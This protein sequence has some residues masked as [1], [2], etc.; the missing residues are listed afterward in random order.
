MLPMEFTL[1]LCLWEAAAPV[2]EE[3]EEE[4]TE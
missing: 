2:A 4:A 3:E 1:G